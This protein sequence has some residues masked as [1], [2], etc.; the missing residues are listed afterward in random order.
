MIHYVLTPF[1]G[2][3]YEIFKLGILQGADA[4]EA[5]LETDIHSTMNT[6]NRRKNSLLLPSEEAK[7]AKRRHNEQ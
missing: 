4:A 5:I 3:K 1:R 7:T 6:Y 2:E